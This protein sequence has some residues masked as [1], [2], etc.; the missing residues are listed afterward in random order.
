MKRHLLL[1]TAALT[2]AS[3][4]GNV[5]LNIPKLNTGAT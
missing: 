3:L 4:A 2:A 1:A 5:N